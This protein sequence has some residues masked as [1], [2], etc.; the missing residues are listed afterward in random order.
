[1]AG[2]EPQG[3][4]RS[5]TYDL[6]PPVAL[7][8]FFVSNKGCI[9]FGGF[10]VTTFVAHGAAMNCIG[11]RYM[12]EVIGANDERRFVV[13]SCT[14][15]GCN[16]HKRYSLTMNKWGEMEIGLVGSQGLRTAD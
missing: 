1:M 14:I 13:S 6:R 16:M 15:R 4:G 12:K 10:S 9:F 7:L 11:D 8:P 3:C 2:I 5:T